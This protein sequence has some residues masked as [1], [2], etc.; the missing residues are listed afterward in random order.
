[1]GTFESRNS[2]NCT[3]IDRIV[4][5]IFVTTWCHVTDGALTYVALNSLSR[6]KYIFISYHF[7]ALRWHSL[8]KSLLVEDK[9]LIIWQSQYHG[10]WWPVDSRSQGISSHGIDL[11][12]LKYLSRSTRKVNTSWP[13][14]TKI[15][16]N[17]GS[18]NGL[19]PDG[20]KP[21]PEPMLTLSLMRFCGIYWEL[22]SW[23]MSLKIMD[24]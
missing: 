3:G 7:S 9:D 13:S 18:G 8:F 21:L 15:W 16:V 5:G 12:L 1:M 11:A 23:I 24:L 2:G 14:D 20:T 22:L 6:Q 4:H 19:L 10:Y 17:I